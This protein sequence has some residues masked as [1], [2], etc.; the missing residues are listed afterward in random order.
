MHGKLYQYT[1]IT[2]WSTTSLSKSKFS[3]MK[4]EGLGGGGSLVECK[5]K[6]VVIGTVHTMLHVLVKFSLLPTITACEEVNLHELINTNSHSTHVSVFSASW[7]K[8]RETVFMYEG[9]PKSFWTELITKTY[10][11]LCCLWFLFPFKVFPI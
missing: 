4:F 6:E 3:P 5:R 11:H 2:E 10:A 8:E 1:S 7:L 9:I